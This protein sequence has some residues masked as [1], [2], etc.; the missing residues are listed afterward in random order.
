MPVDLLAGLR[1]I[2][3]RL[4]AERPVTTYLPQ[5]SHVLPDVIR[6]SG[7]SVT[8]MFAADGARF[9]D[10]DR[11][12]IAAQHERLCSLHRTLNLQARLSIGVH[13]VRGEVNPSEHPLPHCAR[14]FVADLEQ[15]LRQRLITEGR[16]YEN[17]LFISIVIRPRTLI[18]RAKRQVA[19]SVVPVDP[20]DLRV[21]QQVMSTIQADIGKDYGLRRL[22]L[23]EVAG[24]LFSEIA[25][26]HSAIL[27]GRIEPVPLPNGR[28]ANAICSHRP[29][30]RNDRVVE[31]RHCGKPVYAA[32]SGLSVYSAQTFP[33]MFD[34]FLS[35][36]YRCVLSQVLTEMPL[37]DAQA[38]VTRTSNRFVSANDPAATQMEE[39]SQAAD[40]LQQRAYGMGLHSLTLMVLADSEA[41]LETVA[42]VAD[43]HLRR[44]G[45]LISR[46]DW[47]LE[48]AYFGLVPGT[49]GLHP[50]AAPWKTRN[51]A[52]A[53]PLRGFPRGWRNGKWC[54]YGAM[55]VTNGG[56]PYY[57]NPHTAENG[58][59]G[60]VPHT[61]ITG[62]NGSGKTTIICVLLALLMERARIRVV[63]WDKDLGAKLFVLRMSTLR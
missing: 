1:G 44:S 63:L 50:R 16:L 5:Y 20:D 28:L 14:P 30:I 13:L 51:F 56:T 31:L 33:A 8:A 25:E 60:D 21:L 11:G 32:L 46:I 37:H 17:L 57:W 7:G 59:P 54:D 53:A 29:V 15:G 24:R 10:L 6:N 43:S 41:A 3:R 36:P 40:D 35:A 18:G 48:A 2:G 45:S 26:A 62:P 49:E 22:G 4:T 58:G 61:L 55:L 52:A 9:E 47:D 38:L 34:D 42:D 12:Q 23:R 39:L 27:T 19:Q